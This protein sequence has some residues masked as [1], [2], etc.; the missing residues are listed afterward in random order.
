[1]PSVPGRLAGLANAALVLALCACGGGASGPQSSA[2][3][4][5][6][7]VSTTIS[8]SDGSTVQE[9]YGS[10]PKL[11]YSGPG[12]CKGRYFSSDILN[13]IPV[14]FHY[15]SRDAYLVY[16]SLI[17][18]FLSAPQIRPGMLT[19]HKTVAGD[20]IAVTAYCPPPPPSGPLLPSDIGI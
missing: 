17:Y 12:G 13:G 2:K 16:N 4:V 5:V 19:W 1:M 15:S 20:H 6:D 10:Q 11:N 7:G 8:V 3:I 14:T 9:S 18:H